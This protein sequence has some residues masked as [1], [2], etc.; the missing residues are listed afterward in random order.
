MSHISRAELARLTGYERRQIQRM[1][2]SIPGAVRSARDRW[3][4]PDSPEVR[5]WC[6]TQAKKRQAEK[7]R[8]ERKESSDCWRDIV[9]ISKE[10]GVDEATAEKIM[11]EKRMLRHMA[12]LEKALWM[13]GIDWTD[14]V[15]PKLPLEMERVATW[16]L[17][18]SEKWKRPDGAV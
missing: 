8:R 5:D 6:K 11:V 1:A 2:G 9:L 17:R 10:T 13:N 3:K 4:I 14:T 16:M 15:N 12:N 18:F 7:S